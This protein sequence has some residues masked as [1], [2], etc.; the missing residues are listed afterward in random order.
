MKY[1]QEMKRTYF[2]ECSDDQCPCDG[3]KIDV[4]EGYLIVTRECCDFR[5]DCL[6]DEARDAKLQRLAESSGR[7]LIVGG[8][9]AGPI[10]ACVVG[11][12]K[13]GINL[14]VAAKDAKLWWETGRV[15]LRPTPKAGQPEEEPFPLI[16]ILM[17]AVVLGG[18]IL[19]GVLLAPHYG[20]PPN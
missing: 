20:P 6:T 17:G 16:E 12:R 9:F 15:P 13:R 18:F 1:L 14:S 5:K 7:H 3:T 2:T 10:L 4:G 8:G 11:A 19:L